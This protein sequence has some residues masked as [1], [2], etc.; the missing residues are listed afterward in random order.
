[1]PYAF[2]EKVGCIS[3]AVVIMTTANGIQPTFSGRQ[4]SAFLS[5]PIFTEYSRKLPKC[6]PTSHELFW[7]PLDS[8]TLMSLKQ[9]WT[10]L[11]WQ[12]FRFQHI[13]RFG[14]IKMIYTCNYYLLDCAI[15]SESQII[16]ILVESRV[17]DP[18]CLTLRQ[19]TNKLCA[20]LNHFKK[21]YRWEI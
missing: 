16:W 4:N 5:F 18:S 19:H 6:I 3:F 20:T 17:T 13:R 8:V 11:S 1:M 2:P 15:Q 14:V 12:L 10:W 9:Y 21:W 7:N